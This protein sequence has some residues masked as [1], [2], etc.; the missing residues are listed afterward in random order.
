MVEGRETPSRKA[1]DS[2]FAGGE[3]LLAS[4]FVREIGYPD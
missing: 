3:E 4:N 2:G 1:R